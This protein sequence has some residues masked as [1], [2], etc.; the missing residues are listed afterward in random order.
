MSTYAAYNASYVLG[1]LDQ[2]GAPN[3]N[4][5]AEN[6]N[7]R[8]MGFQQAQGIVMDE[9]NHKLYVSD[10]VANR[11]MVFN[12]DNTN[13]LVDYVADAVLG[14]NNFYAFSSGLDNNSFNNPL[15]L[16]ID[17]AGQRLFVADA[18]NFRVL[19]FDVST[20]TNGEA[21]VNVLG[22][23]D[24]TSN[25]VVTSQTGM[26]LP[27]GLEYDSAGQRLFV[28]DA[29]SNRVLVF[30]VAAISDGEA[31]INVIGQPDFV[32]STSG[33]ALNKMSFP[34]DIAYDSAND[35][36]FVVNFNTAKV[37]V[38]DTSAIVDGQNALDEF[39]GADLSFTGLGGEAIEYDGVNQRIYVSHT[40][41]HRVLVYDVSTI[42]TGET[43]VSVLGQPDL[44]TVTDGLSQTKLNGPERLYFYATGNLLYVNDSLNNRI[45]VFDVAAVSNGEAAVNVIGQY[46]SGL[47]DFTTSDAYDS[48]TTGYGL[49]SPAATAI[50]S[51]G[52]RLFVADYGHN[53]ILVF[54]L[55]A[56][57]LPI[58]YQADF[59]LGQS[60]FNSAGAGI[61]DSSLDHPQG[62][63]F[64]AVGQRLFVVDTGNN[65]VV[66]FDVTTIVN[67][68]AAVNVLGQPDLNTNIPDLTQNSLNGPYDVAFDGTGQRLF[69]LDNSNGRV[70]VFDVTTIVDGEA[71]VNV[72]GAPDFTT[73]PVFAG[74]ATTFNS[75][76]GLG[77]DSVGQRLFVSDESDSRVVVFDVS[78]IID[79]EAA[80]NVIGQP[81]L[82]T[83]GINV[84]QNGLAGPYRMD[85]DTN[86]NRLIIADAYAQ[87]V[88]FHDL[89]GLT[90]GQPAA[91][92]FGQD[93]FTTSIFHTTQ[94][95]FSSPEDV[96]YDSLN[97]NVYVT[98][99]GNNRVMI[100]RF[101]NISNA[102]VLPGGMQ[103]QAYTQNLTILNNQGVASTAI[104]SGA[105]PTGISLAA[106]ALGGTPTTSGAFSFGVRATDTLSTGTFSSLLKNFS[107]SI[108]P[109]IVDTPVV[110]SGGGGS[111]G[112]SSGA[113]HVEIFG[114]PA[115]SGGIPVKQTNQTTTGN[116]VKANEKL[117]KSKCPLKDIDEHW[118]KEMINYFYERDVV[119]GRQ[120]C[121]FLPEAA[122]N[123]AEAVKVGMLG[124]GHQIG[125]TGPDDLF[126]DL[127][128]NSW[129]L[130]FLSSA[131]S[132]EVIEGYADGSFR[133]EQDIN[134]QELLKIFYLSQNEGVV[135]EFLTNAKEE[136]VVGRA[137]RAEDIV[138]RAKA[139]EILYKLVN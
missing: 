57:N 96:T 72:I 97:N 32:T 43:A 63:A 44:T 21:A 125:Q 34:Q 75:P 27:T 17:S 127:K 104:E 87:R 6:S 77:Y 81:D 138:S 24:F 60:V 83:F 66:V 55:D 124:F 64:D 41:R 30:D 69:V 48:S 122:M 37:L 90:D 135:K 4:Q 12:L 40:N 85:V 25:T 120:P 80:V 132:A 134:Y 139:M 86:T 50:D 131:K 36:L 76:I 95:G 28:A 47:P 126:N 98:D 105:L 102:S 114:K 111:S 137:A 88:M 7:T 56:N 71:A 115:S 67:G 53:R 133:P 59:V 16:A 108:A 18:A 23:A 46:T 119:E 22:Q 26:K 70:V 33:A 112:G 89:S 73:G 106:N 103:N 92:L 65:R 82:T 130:P 113:G 58:D 91:N 109:V 42:T 100:F 5:G 2:G 15:G 61:S 110:S 68:E 10:S 45:M 19:V 51:S 129:Y 78:T 31:A 101:V 107:L 1:Q 54:N 99:R 52:H 39:G 118:A 11:V 84:D 9:V 3:F 29:S 74:S 13:T 8:D 128:P 121:L 94:D 136:G 38:H 35:R 116:S 14:Q 20:I 123:R 79:G 117:N 49:S 62:L 93:N